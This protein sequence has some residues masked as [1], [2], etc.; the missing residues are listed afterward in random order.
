MNYNIDIEKYIIGAMLIDN[1]LD[2]TGIYENDF[3]LSECRKLFNTIK[4][5]IN[6]NKAYDIINVADAVGVDY[7]RILNYTNFIPTTANFRSNIKLLKKYSAKRSIAKKISEIQN[8]LEQEN[9]DLAIDYKNNALQKLNEI[10]TDEDNT[11]RDDFK[12]ILCE[13]IE[14]IEK[15]YN[16]SDDR[17][18]Y[19]G[20]GQLDKVLAGLHKQELTIIAARPGVGKTAFALQL[21]IR[22][23]KK[24]NKVLFISRE[25]SRVQLAKRIISSQSKINGQKL[26]LCNELNDED[27]NSIVQTYSS[28]QNF[29]ITINDKI[30]TIQEVRQ[31]C[32][33]MK[34]ANGLDILFVDYIGIMRSQTKTESKR[35]EIED[36]SRQLKEI[37]LEFEI[38]VIALCQLNRESARKNEPELSD[39]RESG[40][41][42]QDADTVIILSPIENDNGDDNYEDVKFIIAKQRNGATGYVTLRFYKKSFTFYGIQGAAS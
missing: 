41:I 4:H 8:M 15:K 2:I 10:V 28:I 34:N 36:I 20:F 5:F 25:M 38:P 16:N 21:M 11:C 30:S 39:L 23:A 12:S 17:K 33:Q 13:T 40:A 24:D 9:Y 26:R 3:Y 35:L 14:D 6:N 22:L 31:K 19:T 37:S 32:R 42:E 27:W 29:P 1:T 7:E 18:L